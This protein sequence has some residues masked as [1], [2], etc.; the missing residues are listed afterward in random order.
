V[1][2]LPGYYVPEAAVKQGRLT[3]KVAIFASLDGLQSDTPTEPALFLGIK[4][5]PERRQAMEHLR[6][7]VS[8]TPSH[9][10]NLCE[11]RPVR[12][13]RLGS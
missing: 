9:R 1:C 3:S 8:G 7:P 13:S 11:V 12:G 10:S 6:Y 5:P 4:K 2:S